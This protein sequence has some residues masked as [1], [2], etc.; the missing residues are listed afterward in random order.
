MLFTS[1]SHK[2]NLIK[3]LVNRAKRICSADQLSGEVTK[4]KWIFQENGYPDMVVDRTMKEVLEPRNRMIGPQPCPVYLRLPWL[5]DSASHR[6]ETKIRETTK[7]AYPMCQTRTIFTSRPMLPSSCKDKIPTQQQSNIIYLFSCRC[8]SRYVGKTTQRLETRV[9][10]HVPA[11]L[12]KP[13]TEPW[14]KKSSTSAIGQH[15]LS[16]VEC[17]ESYN[18]SM[19]RILCRARNESVL[20]ILEPLFIH[21]VRPD[22][23]KQLEFVKSL[24]LF[25]HLTMQ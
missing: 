13:V 1:R 4:L 12:L 25:S 24:S 11:S 18:P 22:L 8:G 9:K 3:C 10:Q 15:L 14:P 5:G 20:H 2:L 17:L 16:K 19:F 21:L 23:C 7:R 6:L